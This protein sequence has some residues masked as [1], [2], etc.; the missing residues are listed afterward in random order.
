[1]AVCYGSKIDPIDANVRGFII[2]DT[3]EL[4][5]WVDKQETSRP[6]EKSFSC[7]TRLPFAA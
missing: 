2:S 4:Q 6:F 3:T 5:A 1:M 7:H